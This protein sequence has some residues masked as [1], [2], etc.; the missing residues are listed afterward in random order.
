MLYLTS[1][2]L[3][4][5]DHLQWTPPFWVIESYLLLEKQAWNHQH[6]PTSPTSISR[7][8]RQG[9]L[10]QGSCR[11]PLHWVPHLSLGG[12]RSYTLRPFGANLPVTGSQ[13]V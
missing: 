2:F 6:P 12:G 4:A 10:Q 5:S 7:I 13:A 9:P 3:I 1:M 8:A 11:V